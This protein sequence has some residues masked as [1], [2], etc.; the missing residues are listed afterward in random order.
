MRSILGIT[1]VAALVAAA[2]AAAGG[3]NLSWDDCGVAGVENKTFACDTNTGDR[4]RVYA[5]FVAPAGLDRLCGLES[6]VLFDFASPTVPSWWAV[7]ST[8]TCR[9]ASMAMTVLFGGYGV[10]PYTC[11]DPWNGQLFAGWDWTIGFEA[12]NR[13][14]FRMAG[15]MPDVFETAVPEG[16]EAYAFAIAINRAKTVGSPCT[17]CDIGATL[18]LTSIR[19]AEL[20]HDKGVIEYT[21]LSNPVL[22]QQVNWQSGAPGS[23]SVTPTQARTWGAVKALYR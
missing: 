9:Q 16:T 20:T 12:P 5:S 3:I 11:L 13:A 19:L 18:T 2:P 1:L 4:F 21:V 15:A 7:H 23:P 17:G 10:P 8:G 14:R 22:R 6:Q